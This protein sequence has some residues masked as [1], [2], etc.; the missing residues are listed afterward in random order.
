MLPV[1]CLEDEKGGAPTHPHPCR[2]SLMY[3]DWTWLA[4]TTE[5]E[6]IQF[7]AVDEKVVTRGRTDHFSNI[8]TSPPVTSAATLTFQLDLDTYKCEPTCQTPRS[9]VVWFK[10][11]TLF[12]KNTHT[13]PTDCSIWTTKVAQGSPEYVTACYELRPRDGGIQEENYYYGRRRRRRQGM[14][15]RVVPWWRRRVARVERSATAS[16]V[17]DQSDR[18]RSPMTD[19]QLASIVL[20]RTAD[21]VRWL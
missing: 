16:D 3:V 17:I 9:K 19:A 14:S 21:V 12:S 6:F 8:S 20:L 2:S 15:R 5:Y 13:R 1:A 7:Y 11:Q 18:R 10:L 4:N